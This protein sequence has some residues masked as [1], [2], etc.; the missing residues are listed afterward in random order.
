[1]MIALGASRLT[2]MAAGVASLQPL[3]CTFKRARVVPSVN[4]SRDN[5]GAQSQ[6]RASAAE[7]VMRNEITARLGSRSRIDVSRLGSQE[8]RDNNK[9]QYLTLAYKL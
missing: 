7:G 5:F 2:R 6:G 8:S 4:C 1:M 9:Q 3:R